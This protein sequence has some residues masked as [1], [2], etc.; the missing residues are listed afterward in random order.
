MA[1]SH[2]LDVARTFARA[3]SAAREMWGPGWR[4]DRAAV[5]PG[6]IE[7]L[8]NHVDYNGGPV[9]A[10]A[11]DRATVA[12]SDGCGNPEFLFADFLSDG[13][14]RLDLQAGS[15]EAASPGS[16]RPSDFALG[17]AARSRENGKDLCVGRTVV[18]TSIPI[19]S[20]MSSSAA[21]CV[22]LTLLMNADP[23]SGAELVYD[24]QA[25][26]N[27]T[28]VPC[29][30]MD[31]AASVFGQVIRYE[32]P[33][34]TTSVAPD[35]ATYCFVVVDS[36]VERTL[37]TSS[38]PIRVAECAEAVRRLER[39]W[40]RPIGNLAAL[41]PH[42]FDAIERAEPPVLEP[43]LQARV[44]HI[45]TEIGRVGA[46]EVA[47]GEQD[48]VAFG[49]LMNESGASS[50]GD[51][52]ISHPQVEALV[53]VMRGVP[54]VAGARMMGGGEGGS[55][56]ALLRFDAL[57]ALRADLVDFFD[58]ESMRSSVVPLSFAPGARRM[59]DR[60]IAALLQ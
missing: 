35:L 50:A 18:A 46:G 9:L 58:D 1:S 24:A 10:A 45:V 28:G 19:G 31:Q 52:A 39:A 53:E 32:G 13:P 37:G 43:H 5:A 49:A 21:L 12:L 15:L 20:G 16:P 41:T 14:V 57:D 26:E 54:G 51:Y 23:L 60:E 47:M 34:G 8:G 55:T 44:R 4:P 33:E 29:G 36:R 48:W 7:I 2:E 6:R 3:V 38:Y 27:W 42:D 59:T 22:A 56:L 30:T 25:A 40:D 17:V 11:I